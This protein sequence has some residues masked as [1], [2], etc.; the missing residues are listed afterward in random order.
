MFLF[1][2][3][4]LI[5]YTKGDVVMSLALFKRDPLKH[6]EDVLKDNVS[7]FFSSLV[8][9]PSFKVDI[10]E[11]VKAIY[12]EADMPGIKKRIS[13]FRWKVMCFLSAQKEHRMRRK[14]KK[15]ITISSVH[16]VAL[17]EAFP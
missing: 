7:P 9:P 6:F 2:Y 1:D 5:I 12:I 10:A 16:G 13:R 4:I 14:R 15:D 3:N 11:D 17:T 8:P